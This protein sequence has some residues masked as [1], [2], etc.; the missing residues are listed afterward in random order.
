MP[1]KPFVPDNV[2]LPDAPSNM[3]EMEE[4]DSF[5]VF[6]EPETEDGDYPAVFVKGALVKDGE[7][8]TYHLDFIL[9]E[10]EW[11]NKSKRMFLTKVSKAGV[12]NPKGF[13]DE[14]HKALGNTRNKDA[15]GNLVWQ[16]GSWKAFYGRPVI[17][18]IDS[19]YNGTPQ[20]KKVK[21]P[22]ARAKQLAEESGITF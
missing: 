2:D 8:Q 10:P 19:S 1:V 13:V 15:N 9:T 12:P 18:T 7:K 21:P 22:D 5:D 3:T 11:R 20:V 6:A 16:Y 14:V 17:I 4:D